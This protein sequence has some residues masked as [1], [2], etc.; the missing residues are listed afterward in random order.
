[1]GSKP[2]SDKLYAVCTD[3]AAAVEGLRA[4]LARAKEQAR[5]SE[6]AASRAAEELKAEF[7]DCELKF[8]D[9]LS[10]SVAVHIGP[11]ALACGCT[12]KY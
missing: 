4:E 7:P 8:V 12:V 10:L 9:P 11:G 3:G 5:R 2:S 6:A 1:M